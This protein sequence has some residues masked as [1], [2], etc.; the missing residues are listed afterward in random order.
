M[1]FRVHET[2]N[3]YYRTLLSARAAVRFGIYRAGK[4]RR[5]SGRHPFGVGDINQLIV[6]PDKRRTLGGGNA[7]TAHILR[8]FADERSRMATTVEMFP[9][10]SEFSVGVREMDAQHRH[11]V[12]LLNRLHNAMAAGQGRAALASVLNELAQ[13][14]QAHFRAEEALMQQHNFPDLVSHRAEHERLAAT[15]R[16]HIADL[17]ASK[18]TLTVQ[19]MQFLKEWLVTHIMGWDKEY[20]RHIAA[21]RESKDLAQVA[22]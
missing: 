18:I 13:Y 20:G 4:I 16:R 22:K 9:W 15:V 10:S 11:L 12:G 7:P 1:H 2:G 3:P 8:A 21:A 6:R 19:V 5:V 14:T 17:Q